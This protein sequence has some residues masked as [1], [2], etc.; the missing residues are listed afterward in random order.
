MASVVLCRMI[1][2]YE[3]HGMSQTVRI[4]EEKSVGRGAVVQLGGTDDSH[5]KDGTG[6]AV[7]ET[8]YQR[9][10]GQGEC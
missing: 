3:L 1:L 5:G 7:A 10:G 8:A 2:V 9:V 6:V 4:E